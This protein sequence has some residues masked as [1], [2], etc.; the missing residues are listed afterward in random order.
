MILFVLRT[1]S[2]LDSCVVLARIIGRTNV[3]ATLCHR[4][5]SSYAVSLSAT[6]ITDVKL[7]T[8]DHLL[9]TVQW[10]RGGM[11]ISLP[12]LERT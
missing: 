2:S 10:Q 8:T 1:C 4:S 7:I 12:S 11:R 5:S 9:I 6:P 3:T